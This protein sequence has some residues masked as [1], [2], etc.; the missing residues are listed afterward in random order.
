MGL[1]PSKPCAYDGHALP[2]RRSP[3]AVVAEIYRYDNMTYEKCVRDISTEKKALVS[4][5]DTITRLQR[6]GRSV[7][8]R[9]T[10]RVEHKVA[11]ESLCEQLGQCDVNASLVRTLRLGKEVATRQMATPPTSHPNDTLGL[12]QPHPDTKHYLVF[13]CYGHL[14]SKVE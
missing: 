13:I 12:V 5:D 9:L 3:S 2:L 1:G 7:E 11:L 10:A 4:L 14:S 6:E 8:T